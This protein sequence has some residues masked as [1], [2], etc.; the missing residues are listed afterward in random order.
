MIRQS[1]MV[2]FI[3]QRDQKLKILRKKGKGDYYEN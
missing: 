2:G 1:V 3:S